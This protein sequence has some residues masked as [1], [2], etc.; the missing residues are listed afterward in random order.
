[1]KKFGKPL[2]SILLTFILLFGTVAVG[3]DGLAELLSAWSQKVHAASYG[4]LTYEV[5][6]GKVTIMDC[7][8]SASGTVNIP[9]T[10][11]GYPVKSI[12]YGAFQSCSHLSTVTLPNGLTDIGENC[13]MA[14]GITQIVIP[15]SVVG[16]RSGT[17][18][19]CSKLSS[20]TL[21]E[22]LKYIDYDA[23]FNYGE[24][25]K[26][27]SIPA[28]VVSFSYDESSVES[29]GLDCASLES[30]AVSP[31]NNNFSSYNGVLF[32][33][34]QTI[35]YSYPQG[36]K[37]TTYT[38]P[39][40]V[41][42]IGS[43]A[44]RNAASL[45]SVNIPSSV[46]KISSFAFSGSA[47]KSISLPDSIAEIGEF[48]FDRTGI[49]SLYIG[50][51]VK[52]SDAMCLGM[53]ELSSITVSSGNQSYSA[54]GNVLFSKDKTY[55]IHYPALKE[56]TSYEVP[57]TVKTIGF[58]PTTKQSALQSVE[59]WGEKS[60]TLKELV[61]HNTIQRIDDLGDVLGVYHIFTLKTIKYYGSASSWNQNVSFQRQS[62]GPLQ[63]L[64]ITC[65]SEPTSSRT[66]PPT[67]STTAYRTEPATTQRQ[68]KRE[69]VDII[70]KNVTFEL[71]VKEGKFKTGN[72]SITFKNTW[73]NHSNSY[74]HELAQFCADYAMM[75]YCEDEKKMSSYLDEAGFTVVDKK[76][77]AQRDE[78]NYF[79]ATR[80]IVVNGEVN[81]LVF[82]G[83]I[84]SHKMQWYSNF[85]PLGY[86]NKSKSK[87]LAEGVAHRGFADARDYVFKKLKAQ[88]EKLKANGV[89]QK[90]IQVLL[91]GHSR[92]AATANLLAAKL[93]DSA[94]TE[95]NS[96]VKKRN[97]YVYT[98]AT[99]NVA[100]TN[101]CP[102][103]RYQCIYNIVN[104]EDFVTKVLLRSWGFSRYGMTYTLPSQTNYDKAAYKS[105]LSAMQRYMYRFSGKE[106]EPYTDGEEATYNLVRM[107]GENIKNLNDFYNKNFYYYALT[108][109]K[110][111]NF[112]KLTLLPFISEVDRAGAVVNV[113][114]VITEFSELY[115][116]VLLYFLKSDW[117]DTHA[118]FDPQIA[119]DFIQAHQMTTYCAY[120]KSLSS[121]ELKSHKSSKY[122][123]V[124]CP[125][126]VEVYDNETGELLGRIKDNTI[127][128]T[129]AA[130]DNA[131]VM[132]VNGDSKSYWLP[133]NGNYRVVLTGNDNGA[134][135][136]TVAEIDSDIG[137]TKRASFFDVEI[138]NG[139]S[140][141][142]NFNKTLTDVS[143]CKLILADGTKLAPTEIVDH[144]NKEYQISINTEG[145]GYASETRTAISGDYV[146][147]M[148]EPVEGGEFLG[149]YE[150]NEKVLSEPILSFVAKSNRTLTAKFSVVDKDNVAHDADSST[151][152]DEPSTT[153]HS[154]H[155]QLTKRVIVFSTT[156]AFVLILLVTL[157]LVF[158]KKATPKQE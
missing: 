84:G 139:V 74:N 22:G 25:L 150:N 26:S 104:P 7:D 30:Y 88:I 111:F 19:H 9:A 89:E 4:V 77:N 148:A 91:T 3:S 157:L 40:G 120:M 126:D 11:N 2:V 135:D 58:R 59:G 114:N 52:N 142:E 140:L 1:M 35:L 32:N 85:D 118:N 131:I 38:I 34:N 17:F 121:E 152:T 103:D 37:S 90:N 5:N 36:K 147:L 123:T 97:L 13:F 96:L 21:N 45:S 156:T 128:A 61:L 72:T 55:L 130:K 73:F 41:K 47:L 153:E 42:T 100:L 122:N 20:V 125:V 12:G 67:Q 51:N 134:M 66:E 113:F 141:T 80:D 33:K 119:G 18:S 144:E 149:W 124:N 48:A 60:N 29:A 136:Y 57:S 54:I 107:F 79:I 105:K 62:C 49:S 98:F 93:M 68:E 6:N 69:P 138:K 71:K 78:V 14:S 8:E 28:S 143:D 154:D 108:Y 129:V 95:S 10:I 92:G 94:Y 31:Y 145:S 76:M 133:S 16:I 158:R 56:G 112:F 53:N 87:S 24:G 15:G 63:Q 65:L 132:N 110:P 46:T 99:P 116:S 64:K 83:F 86:E 137:E 102:D 117:F 50:K 109:E 75:G 44:F 115:K 27:I 146:S 43:G 101:S 70:N 155:S 39:S 23:F 151:V 82:A 106:Y 81:K 127:D